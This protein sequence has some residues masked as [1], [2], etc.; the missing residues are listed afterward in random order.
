MTGTH[1]DPAAQPPAGEHVD[2]DRDWF[3]LMAGRAAPDARPALKAEA[4][5]LRAAMLSYRTAAPQGGP[6]EAELRVA[7]LLERARIAGALPAE[8]PPMPE[9]QPPNIELAGTR[10]L[11]RR[12]ASW[13]LGLALAASLA[14]LSMPPELLL[15]NPGSDADPVLRG[16]SVQTLEG[17]DP[18]MRRQQALQ[19]LESAGFRAQVFDRL[20]RPG[21]DIDMPPALS[22]AQSQ[23]L[24]RLGV[25]VPDGPSLQLEFRAPRAATPA[26]AP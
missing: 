2:D 18:A 16:E 19:A 5:W 22:S 12:W 20:G 6:A 23:T 25:R 24:K 14:L 26:S 15:Q 8:A 4:A 3:E 10:P 9:R 13:G 21:L 1:P 11:P 7:R 17:P